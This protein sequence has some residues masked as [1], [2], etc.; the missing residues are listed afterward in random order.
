MKYNKILIGLVAVCTVAILVS[1]GTVYFTCRGKAVGSVRAEEP[2]LV[3]S[4]KDSVPDFLDKCANT[5]LRTVVDRD[6]CPMGTQTGKGTNFSVNGIHLMTSQAIQ[7]LKFEATQDTIECHI[8]YSIGK[9]VI[10]TLSGLKP[11]TTYYRYDDR[12]PQATMVTTDAQGSHATTLTVPPSAHL[13]YL[14]TKALD[15]F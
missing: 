1:L 15:T 6:G 13:L 12:L 10:V 7:L 2:R 11:N 5:P 3:D 8:S 9:S 4:D 14:T